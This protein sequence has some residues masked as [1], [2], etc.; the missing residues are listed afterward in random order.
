MPSKRVPSPRQTINV[1]SSGL[2]EGDA[3]T[4]TAKVT[5]VKHSDYPGLDKITFKIPGYSI[6]ITV[7]E[8][9]LK[10]DDDA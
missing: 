4:L 7:I 5:R 10:S 3:I 1:R 8:Q 6:P 9:S 2:K